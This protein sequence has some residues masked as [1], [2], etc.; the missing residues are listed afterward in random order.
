M[1]LHIR[2]ATGNPA[3]TGRETADCLTFLRAI[4]KKHI[5]MYSTYEL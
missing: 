3:R 5:D 4:F 2:T 1:L